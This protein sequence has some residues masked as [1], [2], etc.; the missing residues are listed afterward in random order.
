MFWSKLLPKPLR[1]DQSPNSLE[2]SEEELLPMPQLQLK[3]RQRK[4][5]KPPSQLKKPHLHHPLSR[6]KEWTWED[7]LIDLTSDYL[8]YSSGN[9]INRLSIFTS[10]KG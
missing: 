8:N 7:S 9:F 2:E 5:R 10:S 1:E 3:K 6:K 4:E